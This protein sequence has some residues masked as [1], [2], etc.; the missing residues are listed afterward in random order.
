LAY[1]EDYI[2][3]N[4]LTYQWTANND[5]RGYAIL[6]DPATK[7]S[8]APTGAKVDTRPSIQVSSSMTGG[9]P[10]VFS[11]PALQVL[12]EKEQQVAAKQ[13]EAIQKD[14]GPFSVKGSA[15]PEGTP[16]AI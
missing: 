12:D 16:L 4:E 8:L 11:A 1:S 2:S 5:A 10:V 6:G 15:Q 3:I 14:A 13:N 7:L 9:L